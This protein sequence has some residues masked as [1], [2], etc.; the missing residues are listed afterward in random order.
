MV[1]GDQTKISSGT[2]I[3]R[4]KTYNLEK[5]QNGT[6]IRRTIVL[7]WHLSSHSHVGVFAKG[8]RIP[9]LFVFFFPNCTFFSLRFFVLTLKFSIVFF[10]F[11]VP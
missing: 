1:S 4:K 2:K 9:E 11:N 6:G 8:R 10:F 3:K 5:R 7:L